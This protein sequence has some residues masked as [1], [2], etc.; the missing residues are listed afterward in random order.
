MSF[1]LKAAVLATLDGKGEHGGGEGLGDPCF[2]GG[3]HYSTMEVGSVLGANG[4]AEI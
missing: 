4:S 1:E 3:S 2:S